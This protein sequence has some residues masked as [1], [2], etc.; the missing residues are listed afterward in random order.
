M[1]EL[2]TLNIK[3]GALKRQLKIF[4]EFVDRPNVTENEL[5]ERC[6][7]I[8]AVY[9]NFERLSVEIE[10]LLQDEASVKAHIK[11]FELYEKYYYET[12]S[13]AKQRLKSMGMQDL[14]AAIQAP[15]NSVKVKLPT[16]SIHPFSG[17]YNQWLFFKD[18]YIKSVHVQQDIANVQKFQ[19][20]KGLL[21]GDALNVIS[22]LE[23]TNDN[24]DEAWKLLQRRYSNNRIIINTHLKGLFDM[25]VISRTNASV[26]RNVIDTTRTHLRSLKTLGEP[27]D[28]WDTIIIYLITNKLDRAT[29][30]DWEKEVD[31]DEDAEQPTLD[32]FTKFLEKR[33]LMLEISDRGKSGQENSQ[34]ISNKKD[35]K[36]TLTTTTTSATQNAPLKCSNCSGQHNI[37]KCEQF[38][39][40][41]PNQRY[42]EA[43]K[44]KLCINCLRQG[45][46]SRD[47]RSQS[48]KKCDLKHNSLLHKDKSKTEVSTSKGSSPDTQTQTNL[49]VSNHCSSK[50]TNKVLLSTAQ[51][52]ISDN[53]G[54]QHICRALLDPGSQVNLITEEFMTR[55]KLKGKSC[56]LP[57]ATLNET[58]HDV[59][60][61]VQITLRS[62]TSRF[63]T[64]ME[65]L[66][67]SNI[68]QNIP[69]TIISLDKL[70]IPPGIELADPIF[71]K[72]GKIAMLIGA[73]LF[74][75]IL[76]SG[77]NI[78]SDGQPSF[79]G[80]KLG[81]IVGGE[82]YTT[83][84]KQASPR[85][86]LLTEGLDARIE[87]FWKTE[88]V[89]TQ[90][91]KQ[92]QQEFCETHFMETHTRDQEGR[93]TVVLP[94]DNKVQLGDSF[95]QAL[96][97]FKSLERRLNNNPEMKKAYT[98]FM[99]DYEKQAHMTP[100]QDD[101]D[102][103]I[104]S[105]YIP[106]QA[107][108]RSSS[109][110]TKVRVVFDASAKFIGYITK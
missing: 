3:R 79:Q 50:E 12:I 97:R 62:A 108:V 2:K 23:A 54:N 75:R 29:R 107:V 103:T 68:T 45:H 66:V 32:E 1:A 27:T 59:Q 78:Q 33:C 38:L 46:F 11:D 39:K 100:I 47:C 80:T 53:D 14:N 67:I 41:Q 22:A 69:Q 10:C 60:R 31:Y 72:P 98:E 71:N 18:S 43:V 26:L 109:L 65:C 93:F 110:T 7:R 20:L 82:L 9:K 101:K 35:K 88:E 61:S 25:P 83:R 55:L 95:E 84:S 52:Y 16:I 28:N 48:C 30:E 81:W 106:Y 70:I 56:K 104:E 8:T 96:R 4:S 63:T 36:V 40:L 13:K 42:H 19:I 58:N 86:F 73:E 90:K 99:R 24:Y 37:Y 6:D 87:Q 89:H 17:E 34:A 91:K 76:E 85:C 21:K 64:Q 15:V 57:V 77:D 74:W 44:L 51:V 105:Y 94:K 49:H 92:I 5:K 102:E